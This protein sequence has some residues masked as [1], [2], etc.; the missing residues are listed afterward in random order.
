MRF[1][2]IFTQMSSTFA[3]RTLRSAWR[4]NFKHKWVQ[5]CVRLTR[6]CSMLLITG[7]HNNALS[8]PVAF[9]K[10]KT[11]SLHMSRCK[12]KTAN[13]W[14]NLNCRPMRWF[15]YETRYS[16][17]SGDPLRPSSEDAKFNRIAKSLPFFSFQAL[18]VLCHTYLIIPRR[19]VWRRSI[20]ESW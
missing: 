17:S 2:S 13:C 18:L 16:A 9:H 7:Y 6:Y 19:I 3:I 14:I 15:L 1:G 12:W 20:E 5:R 10:S 4:M 11:R 8:S